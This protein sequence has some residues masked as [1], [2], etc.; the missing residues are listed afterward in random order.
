MVARMRR[1]V[2]VLLLEDNEHLGQVGQVV[3]VRPGFARNYLF[4]N[5]VACPV[6]PE[7]L[8]RVERARE[9]AKKARVEKARKVADLAKLLE[10]LSLTLEERASEEGHLFGSVGTAAIAA[11]LLDKKLDI[12]ERMIVLEDPLKELGI[13]NVAI[14]LDADHAVEIRVWIVEPSSAAS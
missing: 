6:T 5:G 13:Y 10:G 2:K 3:D 1:N 8:Q 11:A 12:D 9:Q 14:R 7:A 4:P